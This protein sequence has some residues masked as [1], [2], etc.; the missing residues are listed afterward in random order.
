M[1]FS[2]LKLFDYKSAGLATLASGQD[3]QPATLQH[4]ATGWIV[5][6]CDENALGLALIRLVD[7]PALVR[8]IGRAAR[9]E[10]EKCHTWRHTAEQL[11]RI[12]NEIRN[13]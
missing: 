4:E 2:G 9:I 7:D 5:P 10:A 11:D 12:F 1:E 6:P 3:G 13:G 8:R